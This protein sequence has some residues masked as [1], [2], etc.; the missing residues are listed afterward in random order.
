MDEREKLAQLDNKVVNLQQSL[1]KIENSL[2]KYTDNASARDREIVDLQ[3]T[4]KDFVATMQTVVTDLKEIT[5]QN[6]KMITN[7]NIRL[8]T[9]E[10]NLATVSQSLDAKQ[11]LIQWLTL[12]LIPAGVSL[13]IESL[14]LFK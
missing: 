4:L 14:R 1:E 10:D 5:T 11:R 13:I 12:I 3:T 7:M 9:V 2:V 8:T 6:S